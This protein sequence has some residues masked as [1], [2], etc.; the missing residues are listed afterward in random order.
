MCNGYSVSDSSCALQAEYLTS[1]VVHSELRK[2]I[3]QGA[4]IELRLPEIDTICRLLQESLQSGWRNSQPPSR[5]ESLQVQEKV[6][7]DSTCDR[8][9]LKH[10]PFTAS[11][12]WCKD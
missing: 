6:R 8:A 11:D 10:L 7:S 5:P 4:T 12:A 9:E 1:S 3:M 2:L